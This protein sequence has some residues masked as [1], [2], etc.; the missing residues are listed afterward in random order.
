MWFGLWS[1]VG[2]YTIVLVPTLGWAQC[3]KYYSLPHISQFLIISTRIS[4]ESEQYLR[5]VDIVSVPRDPCNHW[6]RKYAPTTT[7]CPR[8][9]LGFVQGFKSSIAREFTSNTFWVFPFRTRAPS[10]LKAWES[11]SRNRPTLWRCKKP[12]P[13]DVSNYYICHYT[14]HRTS[15]GGW[16]SRAR[17]ISSGMVLKLVMDSLYCV[18]DGG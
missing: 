14:T 1:C 13:P 3:V 4:K 12:G 15:G 10:I 8:Y 17:L 6:G 16:Q 2:L 5:D 9:R 11:P 18:Y 7:V